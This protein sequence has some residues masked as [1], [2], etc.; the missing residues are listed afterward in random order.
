MKVTSSSILKHGISRV[1]SVS[2]LQIKRKTILDNAGEVK[3]WWF[4]A[5]APESV[6]CDLDSAWES[7]NLQTGWKLEPRYKPNVG[8]LSK[9]RGHVLHL[10]TVLHLLFHL[11]EPDAELEMEV[12]DSAVR[13]TIN[14]LEISSQQSAFIAGRST[15]TA[16]LEKFQG[17][18]C[19]SFSMHV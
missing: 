8:M 6:L 2:D 18:R 9:S 10:A 11:D 19:S 13:A 7:L 15:V 17:G 1:F 14:F 12:P 4:V 16:E 3:R 5:H